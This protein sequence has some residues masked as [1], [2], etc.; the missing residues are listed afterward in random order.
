M[1]HSFSTARFAIVATLTV[2]HWSIVNADS[3]FKIVTAPNDT[4]QVQTETIVVPHADEALP[5]EPVAGEPPTNNDLMT[6]SSTPAKQVLMRPGSVREVSLSQPFSKALVADPTIVDLTPITNRSIVLQSHQYTPDGKVA[7]R[8]SS[9]IYFFDD[10]GKSMGRLE[11]FVD[12]HNFMKRRPTP[13]PEAFTFTPSYSWV[14]VH[15]KARL[16]S[17]TNFRCGRDGC[18]YVGETTVS[19]PAALPVGNYNSSYNYSGLEAG[20]PPSPPPG[21]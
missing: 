3:S 4:R 16:S 2:G 5:G 15:N 9:D 21:H 13:D 10:N 11:V 17:Q 18:H 8:G 19:E 20:S 7:N 12:E 6:L 1:R 14:E